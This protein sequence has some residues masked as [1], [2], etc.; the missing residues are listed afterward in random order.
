MTRSHHN[1][2][3]LGELL[4]PG[5]YKNQYPK[6]YEAF[7]KLRSNKKIWMFNGKVQDLL[8]KND[9]CGALILLKNRPGEFARRLDYLLRN[10]SC[11]DYIINEFE[12]VVDKISVPVLLQVREHFIWRNEDNDIRV[13][14]PKG[15][16]AKCYTVENN[17]DSIYEGSCG[18]IR[19]ICT[20]A[21]IERFESKESLGKVYIDDSIT[22]Y[23]VPH[24]QRR[25]TKSM[26]NRTR[27]SRV[28]I[29]ADANL[30][31]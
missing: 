27:G 23:C 26:R 31:R 17:L 24:S 1:W 5:E 14:F 22:G 30:S 19:N 11:N 4:H 3:I 7:E 21:I 10:F 15:Q 20:N 16:L 8:D 25:A 18:R 9:I 29:N 2:I 13:F 6:A 12:K 28:T